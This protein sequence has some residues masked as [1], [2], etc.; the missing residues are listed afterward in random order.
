[1]EYVYFLKDIVYEDYIMKKIVFV[2]VTFDNNI[3]LNLS[4]P[5]YCNDINHI[6]INE[7]LDLSKNYLFCKDEKYYYKKPNSNDYINIE[8]VSELCIKLC[9]LIINK[10]IPSSSLIKPSL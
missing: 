8:N 3:N 10:I 9:S 4:K 1:M 2:E 7:S 5:V 6:N